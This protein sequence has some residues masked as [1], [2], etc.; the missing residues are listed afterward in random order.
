M[1]ELLF[2]RWQQLKGFAERL[3]DITTNKL[4]GG[5]QQAMAL[6]AL[7]HDM[8]QAMDAAKEEYEAF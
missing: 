8:R 6:C 7:L 3:E 2:D 1:D 4:H 5:P